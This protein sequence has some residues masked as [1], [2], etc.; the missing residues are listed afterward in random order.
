MSPAKLHSV[1]SF[2]ERHL[3]PRPDEVLEMLKRTEVSS[4]EELIQQAVPDSI[5]LSEPMS[6]REKPLEEPLSE[7]ELLDEMTVLSERNHL[8]K[9]FIGLG[10]YGTITP[11]VLKRN[12]FENPGWYT[13]YTPYQA[14]AAQGKLE[15]LFH[16]QTM[17]AELCSMDI[18][19]S[20]LLD[21][22]T[23]AA[24][25]MSMF[26]RTRH[27]NSLSDS[28]SQ[29]D[30]DRLVF[31]VSES[32][33]PQTID[34][35]CARSEPLGITLEI[36]DVRSLLA[37]QKLSKQCFGMLLQYPDAF[38][39]VKDM[40][41]LIW[42]AK[43]QGI[44]T[45]MAA[46]L[47]ALT[48]IEPPGSLGADV[49]VG[50]TQRFG[51]P[52]AMGGPHAAYFAAKKKYSRSIPGRIVG[53]SVDRLGNQNIYRLSLQTR[54]QHIRRERATSNICTSQV[55][56]AIMAVMYAAYHGPNGLKK[57]A[58]QIHTLT[59]VLDR[60]LQKL[61]Y[62]Q[63]NRYYFDTLCILPPKGINLDSFQEAVIQVAREEKT[64]LC[65]FA[66]R[67]I[68]IS[69]DETTRQEDV[70]HLLLLFAKVQKRIPFKNK[71]LQ[72]NSK[73]QL[74]T[75]LQRTIPY[76]SQE[77]FN[78]FH[79]ETAMMR[80]LRRLEEK[81]LSLN[82]AM[83]PLGSCTMKLNSA[84]SMEPLSQI[85]FARLHPFTPSEQTK[86]FSEI[87][88]RLEKY[89]A[90]ITGMDS[91]SLQPNSGA[92]G[93]FAGLMAIR[94]YYRSNGQKQRDIALVPSS[95]HGTNPASAVMAGMKVIMVECNSMGS[96][97][98]DDLKQKASEW[99]QRLACL[100]ITYPSTHGVFE[101][102]IQ[103]ISNIIHQK[104][105]QV[106]LDGANMNA[107][108]GITNPKKIGADLCHLNLHK[109]F[110]VPHGGGGPGAGPICVAKHLAKFLPSHIFPSHI[111]TESSLETRKQERVPAVS[112]A[113]W[114]NAGILLVAYSYIRM[115]GAEGL[116][117]SSQ[118]AILNAN[119][120]KKCFESNHKYSVLYGGRNGRVAHEMILDIRPFQKFG[121]EAED[122]SKRLIDYGFHPPTMSWPVSG[123]L[124]IE[125]TES[126][127]KEEIERFCS[128]LIQI[129]AEIQ[130]VIDGDVPL[131]ESLLKNAPH[132]AEELSSSKWTH[133]Y[134]R[135]E[136]AF[137]LAA[138]Y[139]KSTY[140]KFWPPVSRVN[141][142][143]GDRNL[144]CTCPPVETY[145]DAVLQ[146]ASRE[147]DLVLAP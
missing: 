23:A 56:P 123:T 135:E 85:K 130:E 101:E 86:G 110:G 95:A 141:N 38:G 143:F 104:G 105:G 71:T 94:S 84:T 52:M 80:L 96:I 82:R 103:E 24:E 30:M 39:S 121:I 146:D 79:S 14:E 77:I 51:L 124:M 27:D 133:P 119:Y 62:Q 112:A 8:W 41:D 125:P 142:A 107:Q 57:I 113:P 127:P 9:N 13:P 116:L 36:G 88:S 114:G 65:R 21:E 126:E 4:L 53:L 132:T 31:F 46:D 10:Y 19:N 89:L 138:M 40:R 28:S 97:D 42:Q 63:R 100:M 136:A 17:I 128:A 18:A 76:L 29:K 32:C 72:T 81:D 87:F 44:P 59:Q 20:S 12:I 35:L 25:A 92:Q 5:R 69:L 49:A 102:D 48:L 99:S 15:T 83:I 11:S 1:S 131:T 108:I 91:V 58:L 129:R 120:M 64:N 137:P 60:G 34:V 16:F 73:P 68:G 45:A 144:I 70:D 33:F 106:Y 26:Y 47:M 98:L 93:E 6:F 109:T 54:E 2:L 90:D 111:L 117:R 75:E 147:E 55:L 139:G 74:P 67:A 50:T 145:Q 61:G 3:G 78:H 140:G 37:D 122:I 134:S 115:L 22:A 66:D 7:N 43:K 118:Y